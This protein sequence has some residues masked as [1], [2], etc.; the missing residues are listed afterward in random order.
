MSRVPAVVEY[1]SRDISLATSVLKKGR[2]T[3]ETY[4]QLV[5]VNK[6]LSELLVAQNKQAEKLSQVLTND[7]DW[8]ALVTN[9]K[10]SANQLLLTVQQD[11]L[12]P[13]SFQITQNEFTAIA[14][15]QQQDIAHLKQLTE[16]RLS[17]NLAKE[18]QTQQTN[19]YLIV[20]FVGIVVL[21]S[22]Y[23]FLAAYRAISQNIQL[24]NEA[25]SLVAE[26]DLTQNLQVNSSDEFHEIAQAFN[27]MIESMRVLISSV[28]SLSHEVVEASNKVQH[29]TSDVEKILPVSSKKH[30]LLPQLL[31]N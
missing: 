15:Q 22:L 30:I 16:T 2:F 27:K 7:A 17:E 12:E 23:F 26:G 28:Q 25:T 6:R 1:S 13:D 21:L 5:A 11:I 18:I 4:T 20:S 19:M 31:V 10:K 14:R 24:I 3:P 8:Q 9:T 29:T